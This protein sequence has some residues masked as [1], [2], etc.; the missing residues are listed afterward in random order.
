MRRCGLFQTACRGHRA[1]LSLD[2]YPSF[3]QESFEMTAGEKRQE[4]PHQ[5]MVTIRPQEGDHPPRQD[6]IDDRGHDHQHNPEETRF[7]QPPHRVSSLSDA[8]PY[9]SL[10]SLG[11]YRET[12]RASWHMLKH[13]S[14]FLLDFQRTARLPLRRYATSE[15]RPHH[16]LSSHV[17][18]H[19]RGPRRGAERL[20]A[21][22]PRE[23]AA[24]P[25]G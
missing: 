10:V 18:A 15:L 4:H 11:Y 3:L 12:H 19:G 25:R 8:N 23:R 13:F 1:R 9:R 20:G 7:A 22:P 2:R 17:H 24:P 14:L 6:E 16:R 5:R 21:P